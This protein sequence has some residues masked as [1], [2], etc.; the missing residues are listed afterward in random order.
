MKKH[1]FIWTLALFTIGFTLTGCENKSNNTEMGS[2]LLPKS[3]VDTVL[4]TSDETDISGKLNELFKTVNNMATEIDRLTLIC[5][6]QAEEIKLLKASPS[7]SGTLSSNIQ[8]EIKELKNKVDRQ[9]NTKDIKDEISKLRGEISNLKGRLEGN[10][11]SRSSTDN[12]YNLSEKIKNIESKV[13]NISD[14]RDKL[15]RHEDRIKS[16]ENRVGR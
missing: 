13:S 12:L 6:N 2:N 14:Y 7:N 9:E 11:A 15:S 1:H 4:F 5:S 16:L 10:S 3:S 8:D